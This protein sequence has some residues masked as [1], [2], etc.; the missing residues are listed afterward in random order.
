ME[1]LT[2]R[3]TAELLRVTPLTVRRYIQD[4]RL[5]AV[6][7]GKGVRVRK[8]AVDQF[9]KP[10]A[11]KPGQPS[12]SLSRGKPFTMDDPLWVVGIADRP[13]DLESAMAERQPSCLIVR[14][15]QPLIG[16]LTEEVGHTVV[17]Y[18]ADEED[19]DAATPPASVQRALSLLGAWSDLDWEQ[20]LDELEHIRRESRP[21]PPITD[22]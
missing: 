2:V 21:T 15:D 5:P 14:D 7:V 20:A 10:V 17:R 8:E 22:L 9:V 18:F 11:P 6:K 16:V 12:P 13:E 4:G 1:L 3:E 19:A